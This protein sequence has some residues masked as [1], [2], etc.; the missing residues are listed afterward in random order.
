MEKEV[1][2][3]HD[4]KF[5]FVSSAPSRIVSVFRASSR[6]SIIGPFHALESKD[7][8]SKR[9]RHG[10]GGNRG[11]EERQ[12]EDHTPASMS[13]QSKNQRGNEKEEKD[14]EEHKHIQKE[15]LP[16]SS[17]PTYMT[18]YGKEHQKGKEPRWRQQPMT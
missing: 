7:R 15:L 2:S 8:M 18:F 5:F 3:S 13:R 6:I 4:F 10:A 14:T 16:A 12:K 9:R 11:I 17:A 1:L